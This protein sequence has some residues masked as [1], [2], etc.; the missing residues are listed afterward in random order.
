MAKVCYVS[1]CPI[2]TYF[3]LMWLSVHYAAGEHPYGNV[4]WQLGWPEWH[5]LWYDAPQWDLINKT[6]CCI[7]VPV[8]QT[9]E[10]SGWVDSWLLLL[11]M[12]FSVEHLLIPRC[13][14]PP[15]VNAY[16]VE[17]KMQTLLKTPWISTRRL[18]LYKISSNTREQGLY[19]F[20]MEFH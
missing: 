17:L 13:F 7:T 15:R 20:T 14:C 1:L 8:K 19:N 4:A 6:T 10:T 9:L 16:L 18:R 12:C 11:V 5:C 3:L 2:I